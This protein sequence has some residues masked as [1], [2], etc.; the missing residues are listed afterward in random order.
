M[1]TAKIW[2]GAFG[3]EGAPVMIVGGTQAARWPGATARPG[4]PSEFD[5]VIDELE[6]AAQVVATGGGQALFVDTDGGGSTLV[7][8][9]P[10]AAWIVVAV[11]TSEDGD[12]PKVKDL[13]RHVEKSKPKG[14]SAG[15]LEVT[16]GLVVAD[17]ALS[18]ANLAKKRDG[19]GL[20]ALIESA[21]KTSDV[22]GR[23]DRSGAEPYGASACGAYLGV[24]SGTYQIKVAEEIEIAENE[25]TMVRLERT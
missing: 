25:Y 24:A 5:R 14:K 22:L 4:K 20:V 16:R 9:A 13:Q 3:T 15:T 18:G 1:G 2:S 19:K 6:N 11:C 23:A 8:A 21:S 7:C 17:S 12:A 10:D